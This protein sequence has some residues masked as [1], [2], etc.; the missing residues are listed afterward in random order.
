MFNSGLQLFFGGVFMLILSPGIDDLHNI[1][2]WQPEALFALIY[3]IIFG[4]VLA[5]AAY[6]Y[7]L[8]KLPVGIAT[9]YAY[10]NPLIAVIMGYIVLKEPLNIYTALAFM[11]IAIGVFIVNKGYRDQHK[12]QALQK[13]EDENE[14]IIIATPQID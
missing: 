2:F 8:S 9:I 11:T 6:M 3:L 14:G 10:I 4:S 7:A 12:K 5:Y 1:Q 13:I